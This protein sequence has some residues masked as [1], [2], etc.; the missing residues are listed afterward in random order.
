[1][2]QRL[3]RLASTTFVNYSSNHVMIHDLVLETTN[4]SLKEVTMIE[5]SISCTLP[6][7]L[8]IYIVSMIGSTADLAAL[9]QTSRNFCSISEP[10]LYQVLTIPSMAGRPAV[11]RLESLARAVQN[12]RIANIVKYVS[13]YLSDCESSDYHGLHTNEDCVCNTLDELLGQILIPLSNLVIIYINCGLHSPS[14]ERHQYLQHLKTT[15]LEEVV[16]YCYCYKADSL[17]PFQIFTSTCMQT[18]MALHC[19][20]TF[21]RTTLTTEQVA[22]AERDTFLPQLTELYCDSKCLGAFASL[23]RKGTIT[24]L[25]CGVVGV[26]LSN[27]LA[28][29]PPSRSHLTCTSLVPIIPHIVQDPSPFTISE[30]WKQCA[31]MPN[32]SV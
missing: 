25:A 11:K 12:P 31:L 4:S 6:T 32:P 17:V 28:G 1:M 22:Y 14:S 13:K 15:K 29:C 23:F 5:A 19:L 8:W 20:K 3:C 10:Y 27:L 21:S 30:A 26:E 18:V 9:C 24:K 2:C 7:E 16:F